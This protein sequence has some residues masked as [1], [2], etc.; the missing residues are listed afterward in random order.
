[1][2]TY[3]LVFAQEDPIED[4]VTSEDVDAEEESKVNFLNIFCH[5]IGIFNIHML[6]LSCFFSGSP[7][8]KF[9]KRVI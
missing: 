3:I 5:I 2:Y 9:Y 4:E 1:M 6:N 7:M 8:K